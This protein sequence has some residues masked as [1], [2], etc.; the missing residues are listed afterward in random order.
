MYS[1]YVRLPRFNESTPRDFEEL[2]RSLPN[3]RYIIVQHYRQTEVIGGASFHKAYKAWKAS[4][5]P[6]ATSDD[7]SEMRFM[8]PALRRPPKGVDIVINL[9]NAPKNDNRFVTRLISAATT[10]MFEL[11]CEMDDGSLEFPPYGTR[12]CCSLTLNQVN[13]QVAEGFIHKVRI[14]QSTM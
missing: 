1:R 7:T 14:L 6:S 9:G 3:L 2:Q 11:S 5:R 8:V 12:S 4:G 13:L 10:A